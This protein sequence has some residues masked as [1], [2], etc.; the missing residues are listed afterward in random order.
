MRGHGHHALETVSETTANVSLGDLNGDGNLDIVP[1]KGRHWPLSDVVLFGDGR[2]HFTPGPPLP[3]RPGEGVFRAGRHKRGKP[4][5]IVGYVKAPGAV[6]FN[7]GQG[8][9]L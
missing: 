2:G 1:A 8:R 3:N 9:K 6:Y 5:I 7:G 4:D